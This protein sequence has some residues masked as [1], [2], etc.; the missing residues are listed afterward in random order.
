LVEDLGCLENLE[1]IERCVSISGKTVVDA[2]CGDMSF[3]RQLASLGATV[4]AID[5]DPIQA[6]RNRSAEPIS[7]VKYFET[8]AE[9]LP[10]RDAEID[11]VFFVY[12]L[13]HVPEQQIPAVLDEVCRVL[14]PDGFV[15]VI[16]PLDCPLLD[17]MSLFHDEQA[18]RRTVLKAL[19]EAWQPAFAVNRMMTY[20]NFRPFASFDD[21]ARHFAS[22]SF[23]TS[24]SEADIRRPHVE[25]AFNQV[26][27]DNGRFKTPR[28][29]A[30]LQEPVIP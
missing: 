13:H 6:K 18:A 4:L 5:P 24:Y 15:M 12:S 8:G 19:R 3:S 1:C 2:G 9:Q 26:A 28:I 29:A 16:E 23:N 30:F 11:G 7:G 27:V 17:V 22:R 21:F 10:A 25:A 14:K 20:H